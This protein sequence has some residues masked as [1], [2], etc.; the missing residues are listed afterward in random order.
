MTLQCVTKSNI[1]DLIKSLNENGNEND[2]D[3]FKDKYIKLFKPVLYN[4]DTE[5]NFDSISG[6]YYISNFL[7]SD[8]MTQIQEFLNS[9]VKFKP[10]TKSSNSRRVA[11]FGYTYAYDRSGVEP[12]E[13]IP[14]IFKTLV[15]SLKLN[16]I[17]K[18]NLI[19]REFDQLIINEYT[20]GQEIAYHTDHPV[21]FDDIIA[22][23]TIGQSVP[24][25][26][27]NGND[28]RKLDIAAGSMYI[29]TGDSR[30]KWK[31]HLK[32]NGTT[33]RYSLTYRKVKLN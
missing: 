25:M 14:E 16:N 33:N 10:I 24:I 19:E 29:M 2:F 13:P 18:S 6:L 21:Q 4:Y 1:C 3:K 32:N 5:T 9:E 26:F 31:H 7:D 11:Q 15:S 20:P 8:E 30:Y 12:T 27:R 22:C 17:V 28:I 23:I